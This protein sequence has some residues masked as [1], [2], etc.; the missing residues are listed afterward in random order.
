MK[1]D[2]SALL[3]GSI[4]VIVG[5]LFSGNTLGLWDVDVF[6]DGWWTLF[7]IIPGLIS[8]LNNGI[9]WGSSIVVILGIA[10]LI[11]SQ[12]ILH[13][14]DL[15][16]LIFPLAITIYGISIIVSFFKKNNKNSSIKINLNE[17][18]KNYN[19]RSDY[20]DYPK[21][22]VFLGGSEVKNNSQNLQG[23]KIEVAL[24][25]MELDLR[26]ANIND[27]I[28]VE[29]SSIL[30]GVEIYLPDDVG[31][32]VVS[33]TPILGGFSCRKNRMINGSPKIIIKY[34]LVMG[35]IEII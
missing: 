27:D 16:K 1:R 24:G 30:G 8:I 3:W 19:K 31:V 6:F 26:D 23:A 14:I 33:G 28:L 20:S 17:K 35:G 11:D 15:W 4:I 21:Y 7:L 12:D 5:V 25:A 29:I 22:N 13:G 2:Y 10:L 9:A 34:T 32:E 18:S